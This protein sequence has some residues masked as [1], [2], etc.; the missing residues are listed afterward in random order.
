MATRA[1]QNRP[2]P[3]PYGKFRDGYSIGQLSE[4]WGRSTAFVKELIA[5][6]L[7]AQREDGSISEAELARYYKEHGSPRL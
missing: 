4:Q 6:D 7:L 2:F 3:F 5:D 1:S